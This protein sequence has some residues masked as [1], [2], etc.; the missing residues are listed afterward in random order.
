MIKILRWILLPIT[1]I[2]HVAIWVRNL[3]FDKGIFKSRSFTIPTIVIGNLAVG[4][5]GKSPLTEYLIRL[6]KDK[7]AIA[8]LSRGYGR[9][10]RGFREVEINSKSLEVGD[11]PLQFKTKFP[12][13]TV[14]VDE[15][16]CEGIEYLQNRQDVIILDDAFQHRKLTPGFAILLFDF[17]SLF[18]TI[19]M[20]PT[21]D[22]R[23]VFSSTKRADVI[24][25]TKSPNIIQEQEKKH[26][27]QLI[28]KHSVAPIF[29]TKI[30][31]ES[32]KGLDGK[33]L[34][35]PLT[36]LD[37]LLFCGIANPNPLI[38][39]LVQQGNTIHTIIF[40][41]HYNYSIK[42]LEKVK[43]K[44][45]KIDSSKK[46]ILT[47][48]KDIQRINTDFFKDLP[49]FYIPIQLK[50]IEDGLPSFNSYINKY[51]ENKNN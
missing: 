33:S 24:V 32:P 36:K 18:K 11:E 2:Y 42:D 30:S 48:E 15:N 27:E 3:L 28:R 21:G 31:Y 4:G 20:L 39:H 46:I 6:L 26:I 25:I 38:E 17:Q 45:S 41:D 29:Y 49:L 37:I 44:F 43:I 9:N 12:E 22:F 34:N 14:A 35:S 19:L 50:F 10:T 40:P 51:I 47:T 16:R 7:Y 1:L 13:I 5:T 23:D 8:T